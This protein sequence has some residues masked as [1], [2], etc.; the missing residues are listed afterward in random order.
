MFR[1]IKLKNYKSLLDI[2]VNLTTKKGT[3]RKL[4]LIYGENGVGK[5]NF[6]S[7]FSTLIDTFATK[8]VVE[9][10]N[11][12]I[13][14]GKNLN[15][16][17]FQ[18]MAQN[19]VDIKRIINS[20]KTIN[21]K[22]NMALEFGF[23][24]NGKN[25]YYR[26]ETDNE[27]IVK[28]EFE[29]KITENKALK[30]CLKE[31]Q[32]TLEDSLFLDK[33]YKKEIED[34][35][36]KYWGKHSLISLIVFEQSDKKEGYIQ[37][38]IS[39]GLYDAITAFIQMSIRLTSSK[40]IELSTYGS[41]HFLL[42][43]PFAGALHPSKS[44][45]IKKTENFFSEF[46][47]NL[48]S[49]IKQVYYLTEERN[50]FIYYHLMFKKNI[51]GKLI[52]V[53][54]ERESTG[55]NCLVSLL[56]YFIFCTEGRTTVI[57]EI[58]TNLHDILIKAIIEQLYH[59]IKDQLIITTHNTMLLESEILRSSAY[60]FNVDKKGKKELV[61]IVDFESRMHPNLNVRKRYTDGLYGGTPFVFCPDFDELLEILE[62]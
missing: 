25:G 61:P 55:T 23:R 42:E 31:N 60:V 50:G 9:Q 38:K 28:E 44:S 4:I 24:V 46:F 27:K 1:Y 2:N 22:D 32:L 36:N 13:E 7:V 10:I 11:K 6:A 53:E 19:L 15:S 51:E 33:A 34:L 52:D 37:S 57:D 16:R 29:Y 47:T 18:N 48:Y 30:F 17:A 21:S 62:K 43:N 12:Y 5:S 58:E 54:Y 41:K 45:E 3:P 26:I 56:P 39:K 59:S 49:D 8:S 20:S 40:G 35:L 14:S